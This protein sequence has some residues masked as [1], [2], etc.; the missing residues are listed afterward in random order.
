MPSKSG[1][2]MDQLPLNL[3]LSTSAHAA[4]VGYSE[5]GRMSKDGGTWRADCQAVNTRA[6]TCRKALGPTFRRP[7]R[8][9]T[10]TLPVCVQRSSTSRAA[11]KKSLEVTLSDGVSSGGVAVGPSRRRTGM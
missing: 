2:K 8:R 1:G 5:T 10:G 6:A 3:H 9:L 11:E 4:K 7:N